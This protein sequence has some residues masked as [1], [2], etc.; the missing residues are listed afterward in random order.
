VS[1]S[2]VEVS[3]LS[4][5]Y[6]IRKAGLFGQSDL[7]ALDNVSF[8]VPAGGALGIVGESGSG[9]TTLGRIIVGL[10]RQTS[11]RVVVAGRERS[12]HGR[13]SNRER[14][15]RGRETAM[16][17]Q[18]PYGS[19]DPRQRID[20]ALDEILRLHFDLS[21]KARAERV[22]ELLDIVHLDAEHGRAFPRRLSGGQRQRVAIAK[23]LATEAQLI[24]LDEA[25]AALD[26]SIQAQVLNVL[27]E[28]RERT[29]VAFLFITHDL[30]VV[31]QVTDEVLVL[32]HG[33]MVERGRTDLVLDAPQHRYT[34]RLLASVPGPGWVPGKVLAD[35]AE[36]DEA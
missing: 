31:R 24:V 23:A 26:V 8:S 19:L 6:R 5:T 22:R 20:A 29:K 33:R 15:R 1:E 12:P 3:G 14:R 11:G 7:V 21:Q 18:N 32:R 28:I 13:V 30:G 27:A 2:V 25:V 34:Q 4:K 35:F 9:K 10:E 16:V 36:D 17:F